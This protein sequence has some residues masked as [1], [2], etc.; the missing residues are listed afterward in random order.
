MVNSPANFSDTAPPV[1]KGKVNSRKVKSPAAKFNNL[2][3]F[4]STLKFL[5]SRIINTDTPQVKNPSFIP[6]SYT[7]LIKQALRHSMHFYLAPI[8]YPT[9]GNASSCRK[10][11]LHH[12]IFL[13]SVV[14]DLVHIFR[15]LV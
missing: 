11:R 2:E 7:P 12:A 10:S 5:T 4:L 9:S 1:S 3:K 6:T 15:F 13:T 14:N 8:N